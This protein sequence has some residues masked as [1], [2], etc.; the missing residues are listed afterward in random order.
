[1]PS[2]SNSSIERG[3]GVRTPAKHSAVHHSKAKAGE[4]RFYRQLVRP[5]HLVSFSVTIAESDLYISAE[6]DLT[7]EARQV[8]LAS[9]RSIERY[10]AGDPA[11]LS[12]LSP[13]DVPADAP[14][15]VQTMANAAR[16]ADVGPMA[17]VAGAIAEEVGRQ[18]LRHTS[19]VLVENGGDIFLRSLTPRRI[20]IYA[21]SSPFSLKVGLEVPPCPTGLGICTSAATVGHSLSF[22]QADAVVILA[23]DAA[24][25]DAWATAI[26]N[27]VNTHD[28]IEP[29]LNRL[30]TAE[31]V[32]GAVIIV[33]DAL[34]AWGDVRLTRV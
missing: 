7:K 30:S 11:F 15:L 10:A 19:E 8:L 16:Q 17:A 5:D 6:K 14:P 29:A 3:R 12:S 24:L 26:G 34:G 33:G 27:L 23:P 4:P 2:R 1:M 21:G 13:V 20:S 18:L 32:L 22:G 31:Q 25:A 28:D 9:R